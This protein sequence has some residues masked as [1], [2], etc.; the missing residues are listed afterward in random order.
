MKRHTGVR[1]IEQGVYEI[2]YRSGK[3]RYFKRVDAISMQEAHQKR[4]EEMVLTMKELAVTPEEKSRLCAGLPEIWDSIHRSLLSEDRPKKT[5]LRYQ[6]TFNRLFVEFKQKKFLSMQVPSQIGLSYFEEYKNYYCVDLKRVKGWRAELIIVKAIINRM[7]R[8]GYCSD[9]LVKKLKAIKKPKASKKEYPDIPATK[10]MELLQF[11]KND[12]PD[13]Y[14]PIRFISRTGRRIEETSLI[15][16]ADVRWD[17][18]RPVRINIRAET[19][20]MKESAPLDSLDSDLED[21]IQQAYR[22]GL[23]HKAPQLFLSKQGKKCSQ[24]RIRNYLKEVSL[25]I[26]EKE[27]T[28]HYF[29]HR[30]FTECGK[31]NL[32]IVD[33]MA[34][35]GLKDIEVMTRY[36]SHSTVMG[37]SNVLEKTGF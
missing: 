29:R 7:N 10:I 37:R 4:A 24:S 8:L 19:T 34:I 27:I 3:R 14:R 25:K 18:I 15:E 1:Q 20:K 33:V 21:I 23:N 28:P 36:Y 2:N 22:E 17:G 32:P 12:R 30:F 16:R 35:S 5:I 11:I 26:I 31:N 13:Y 9:E 6:K